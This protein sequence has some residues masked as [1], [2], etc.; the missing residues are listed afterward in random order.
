MKDYYSK[1]AICAFLTLVAVYIL[2][3]G[4]LWFL[5]WMDVITWSTTLGDDVLPLTASLPFV[6][7]YLVVLLAATAGYA[8][9]A[10]VAQSLPFNQVLKAELQKKKMNR[11]SIKTKTRSGGQVTKETPFV[12]ALTNLTSSRLP[13]LAVVDPTSRQ[14]TGVITSDDILRKFQEEIAKPDTGSLHD[15]LTAQTVDALRPRKP[16]V[17]AADDDLERVVVTMIREQF[18]KLIVVTTKESNEFA[19]TIDVLDLVGEIVEDSSTQ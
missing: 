18:T 17:A 19:G 1:Q 2:M 15:R 6:A 7:L 12:T 14:V 10:I 16:V 11:A 3:V 4:I 5:K 8:R 13:I 9:G